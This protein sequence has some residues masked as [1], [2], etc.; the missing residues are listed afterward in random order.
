MAKHLGTDHHELS[1]SARMEQEVIPYLPVIYDEPFA[2]SSQIPTYLV[3]Q[4]A[5]QHVKVALSGDGGD[6]LFAVYNRYMWAPRIWGKLSPLP[7]AA[8][9]LFEAALSAVPVDGLSSL[10]ARFVGGRDKVLM[11]GNKVHK[12][13]DCLKVANDFEEM[14]RNLV[15][16]WV[17]PGRMIVGKE[18]EEIVEPIVLVEESR[19]WPGM[20][21][22]LPI[23][24]RD[25]MSYLPDDILCT[26][27]RAAMANCL[28]TRTP[29][30][31]HHVLEM[32]WRIPI[33]MKIRGDTGKWA[34]RNVLYKYVPKDLIERPKAGFAI[35]IGQWLR[36]PLREWAEN[37]IR[38][39]R[40]SM[41]G[42]LKPAL[43]RKVW[44]EHL[45]GQRDHTAKI[46]S[47]LMFQAWLENNS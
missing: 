8:R 47:V 33:E 20:V 44:G 11:L 18:G 38:E 39:R 13:A 4:L 23:M 21:Q 41:E 27:D 19:T 14:H 46:W 26:V 45:S 22:P 29:F 37:L 1:V 43:I 24:Y 31:N 25:T 2:D 42:Y 36:G 12:L 30:L 6:E 35:P 10:C 15:S 5:S 34:L 7:F 32:A 16:E 28:E 17:N 9:K 40:L 3:C